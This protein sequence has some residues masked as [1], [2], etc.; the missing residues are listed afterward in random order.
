[1]ILTQLARSFFKIDTSICKLIRLQFADQ[2]IIIMITGNSLNTDKPQR[3]DRREFYSTLVH[4]LRSV[5]YP[6]GRKQHTG[7]HHTSVKQCPQ[8]HFLVKKAK[9][10]ERATQPSLVR[11]LIE[12]F[13][14]FVVPRTAKKLSTRNVIHPCRMVK[15]HSSGWLTQTLGLLKS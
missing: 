2:E 10:N 5:V 9:N 3:S 7:N 4:Y 1:M 6:I 8:V 15:H 14:I 11:R 12:F 13:Y